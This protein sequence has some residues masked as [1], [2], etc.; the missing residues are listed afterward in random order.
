MKPTYTVKDMNILMQAE[1]FSDWLTDVMNFLLIWITYVHNLE[2]WAMANCQQIQDSVNS[3]IV[4]N[5]AEW[6]G[7]AYVTT[8]TALPVGIFG[9]SY[10]VRHF[11]RWK[12]WN[13]RFL[14]KKSYGNEEKFRD[15]RIP[16]ISK[17][18]LSWNSRWLGEIL[19]SGNRVIENPHS[20]TVLQ[21]RS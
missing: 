20:A 10:F 1:N 11:G 15:F 21:M 9:K 4:D 6:Y 19:R 16:K 17:N 7:Q 5:K 8:D 2:I 12:S 18:I 14:A 13:A 3:R